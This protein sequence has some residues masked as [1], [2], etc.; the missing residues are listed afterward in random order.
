MTLPNLDPSK[1]NE[2]R[3][4]LRDKEIARRFA[5]E[6]TRSMEQQR[7]HDSEAAK[8]DEKIE[9]LLDYAT[10]T[11]EEFLYEWD[12]AEQ[13]EVKIGEEVVQLQDFIDFVDD[14]IGEMPSQGWKPQE[15]K[16]TL[17]GNNL[18]DIED[19]YGLVKIKKGLEETLKAVDHGKEQL[20]ERMEVEASM[21]GHQY[22]SEDDRRAGQ[23]LTQDT[24][25]NELLQEDQAIHLVEQN[26]DE[27]VDRIESYEHRI[28]AQVQYADNALTVY[29]EELQDTYNEAMA[30]LQ[31]QLQELAAFGKIHEKA[32]EHDYKMIEEGEEKETLLQERAEHEMMRRVDNI[33]EIMGEASTIASEYAKAVETV[34][35]NAEHTREEF[36]PRSLDVLEEMRD[37]YEA[38]LNRR[39]G[40]DSVTYNSMEDLLNDLTASSYDSVGSGLDDID[41]KMAGRLEDPDYD[42]LEPA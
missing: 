35:E 4:D 27:I 18:K 3:E 41:N 21:F 28:T 17:K 10:D 16:D 25:A 33:E 2:N 5:N 39:V 42:E 24:G 26:R 31:N 29:G 6:V 40:D 36:E 37:T 32:G 8:T 23:I 22:A 15:V 34:R 12:T 1:N 9:N 11:Q 13:R 20:Q 7:K 14:E 38:V 19:Q 30:D